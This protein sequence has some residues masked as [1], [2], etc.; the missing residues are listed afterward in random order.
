MLG[1]RSAIFAPLKNLGLIVMDEEQEGSYQS[2]NA[3]RYDTREVA[4]YLCARES[5]AL[6]LGSATPTVESAWAAEQL[7]L[8]H[9]SIFTHFP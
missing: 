2:E 6:V 5:A 8:I 9:I 3:P 4:K 7:S 1:T